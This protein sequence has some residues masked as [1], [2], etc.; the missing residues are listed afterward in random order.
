MIR[1]A[2][3]H[4]CAFVPLRETIRIVC[5]A[6]GLVAA[7]HAFAENWD[8]FRGP[9]GAGQSD[10]ASIPTKWESRH[11]LWKKP[12]PG[13]G[14]SSPVIWEG[15]LFLTSANP[16]TGEQIVLAFDAANGNVLW[17][18]RLPPP[19]VSPYKHHDFNSFASS[20]PAVDAANL[21]VPWLVGGKVMLAAFRHNGDAV[22][23]KEL[24]AYKEGH[25]FGTSPILVDGLVCLALNSEADSAVVALDGSTGEPRWRVA[26]PPGTTSFAT[27]CVL[28]PQADEKLLLTTSTAAGLTA[29]NIK[30]GHLAWEAFQHDVPQR[31]VGSPVIDHGM[32]LLTCGQGGAG[33]WLIA[34]RSTK[35][36]ETPREIY[37]LEQSVSYVPTPVVANDLLFVWQD[38]GIVSCFDL[39]S[40]HQNWR[41]RLGGDYFSSPLKIGDRIFGISKNGEVVVLA[42]DRKFQVLARNTLNE[43]CNATPAV[44]NGRLYLRTESSLMCVGEP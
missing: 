5:L 26:R 7:S 21:Y 12:L 19:A 43:A 15:K 35:P 36:N 27:P 28:N 42:A 41:E 3:L 30:T 34:A 18:Q 11:F 13:V 2:F 37:R 33:K 24:G 40:G 20:T 14:H 9:N 23:R 16:E 29:I 25:G 4:L 10:G 44:V 39:E 31:C 8:R 6:L 32:I 17:D 38:R 1:R 22:W